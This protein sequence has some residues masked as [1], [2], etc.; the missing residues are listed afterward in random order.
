MYGRSIFMIAIDHENASPSRTTIVLTRRNFLKVSSLY[1]SALAAGP[2]LR[3]FAPLPPDSLPGMRGRVAKSSINIHSQPDPSSKRLG[4]LPRDTILE[5]LEEVI[6]PPGPGENPRWYRIAAGFVH[7]AYIQRVDNAHSSE[8]SQS[9]SESGQIGEVSVPI[10]QSI[11]HNRAG[12]W[13]PL[14][15]LYYKSQHWITGIWQDDQGQA[16]YRLVDDWLKATYHARADTIRVLSPGDWQPLSP[17]VPPTQK[18][19]E[20]SLAGQEL[21]AYEADRPVFQIR[22]STGKRYMETPRGE[23]NINRKFPGKHM[24]WGMITSNPAAY[25]LVGVPWV[26]FFHTTGVAFHGAYWHDNFGAP[27]SQGCVN[28]QVED[29]RWLF[30][31]CNPVYPTTINSRKDWLVRGPGTRVI[32][33]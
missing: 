21:T 3:W 1:L 30:R 7:S 27:M 6:S 14:Y 24:G 23:F 15:R 20:V 18:R 5:L 25:E 32:I 2:A 19:I 4:K 16:W 13:V 29:A 22:V 11:Y 8:P 17:D 12:Y 28:M 26:S 10:S 9:I 33:V 31:W